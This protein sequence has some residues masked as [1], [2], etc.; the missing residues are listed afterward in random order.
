MHPV[1]PRVQP[2]RLEVLHLCED[3]RQLAD[4]L[5][6]QVNAGIRPYLLTNPTPAGANRWLG[7]WNE[8]REW[9]RLLSGFSIPLL[10]AHTFAAG[11]AAVRTDAA[12]VYQL[13]EEIDKKLAMSGT[14]MQRSFRAAEQ[15]VLTQADAVITPTAAMR[16]ALTAAG[17]ESQKMFLIPPA[18]PLFEELRNGAS[19]SKPAI[20]LCDTSSTA[21]QK[22]I[23]LCRRTYHE[24]RFL[25]ADTKSGMQADGCEFLDVRQLTSAWQRSTV[26]VAAAETFAA[27]AMARGIPVIAADT[28]FLRELS[29]NGEGCLWFSS[30]EELASKLTYLLS[31][32]D[33][34]ANLAVAGRRHILSTRSADRI[35]KLY[36]GAYEYA[37]EHHKRPSGP[38]DLQPAMIPAPVM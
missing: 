10:H 18:V 4:V 12:A 21:L 32:S 37:L 24:L 34:R 11:M 26:V 7:S 31:H 25:V 16:H 23:S 29:P 33:F 20:V 22:A 2:R 14:W 38:S 3:A 15:F 8:V 30:G 9:R 35:G 36:R 27:V 5:D 28:L 6:L 17:I 13:T 1:T 19:D